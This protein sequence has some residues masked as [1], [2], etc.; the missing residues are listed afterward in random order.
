MFT[1]LK[2]LILS[3]LI[4]SF[5]SANYTNSPKIKE[6]IEKRINYINSNIKGQE[7][8]ITRFHGYLKETHRPAHQLEHIK[9][10]IPVFEKRVKEYKEELKTFQNILKNNEKAVVKQ[11]VDKELKKAQDSIK[12]SKVYIQRYSTRKNIVDSNTKRIKVQEAYIDTLNKEYKE[13][14]KSLEKPTPKVV[15]LKDVTKKIQANTQEPQKLQPV[16]V[17]AS[18]LNTTTSLQNVTVGQNAKANVGGV[19]IG[20]DEENK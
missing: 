1:L 20:L 6:L 18:N 15:S 2:Y 12:W 10:Q 13:Y 11:F 9:A 17:K 8:N 3:F 19:S 7:G 16:E 5:S 14:L 4:F